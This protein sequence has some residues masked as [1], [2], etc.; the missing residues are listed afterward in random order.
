MAKKGMNFGLK[1]IIGCLIA[2]ALVYL[3]IGLSWGPAVVQNMKNV[4]YWLVLIVAAYLFVKFSKKA[5]ADGDGFDNS[6]RVWLVAITAI[7]IVWACAW[8]AAVQ[9]RVGAPKVE[10]VK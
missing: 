10:V 3:A 9:E 4:F 2:I 1:V 6:S 7:V 5:L 8:G